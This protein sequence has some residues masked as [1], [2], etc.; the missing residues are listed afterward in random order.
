MDR[1]L[2]LHHYLPALYVTILLSAYPFQVLF[3]ALSD[4]ACNVP[5]VAAAVGQG[6]GLK[7]QRVMWIL[8]AMSSL[9]I[10]YGFY[11]FS[12]ITYG[13]PMTS[14]R[15]KGLRW[16]SSW[17]INCDGLPDAWGVVPS[18]PSASGFSGGPL[19]PD[20]S[21]LPDAD[22]AEDEPPMEPI[23]DLDQEVNKDTH[24]EI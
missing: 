17:D 6:S 18:T 7:R 14:E 3:T 10:I 12:P 4:M 1:Q 24:D 15:C 11:Q 22:S 23:E 13:F 2:F 19:E 5:Q 9:T 8:T 21:D 20:V 16:L